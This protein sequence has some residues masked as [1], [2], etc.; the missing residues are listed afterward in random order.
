VSLLDIIEV[1]LTTNLARL[2]GAGWTV[3]VHN[4]YKLNGERFTFWLFT[5]EPTNRFVKG[6]GRTDARAVY[7]ALKAS[8]LNDAG[9]P[10]QCRDCGLDVLPYEEGG[11]VLC[12]LCSLYF[13]YGKWWSVSCDVFHMHDVRCLEESKSQKVEGKS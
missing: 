6:E 5:H 3:A 4:D 11:G 9:L 8:R 13:E 7:I 1:E 2:R 10:K 12:S